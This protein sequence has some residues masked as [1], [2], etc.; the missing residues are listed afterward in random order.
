MVFPCYFHQEPTTML[1][2]FS[3]ILQRDP[4]DTITP[5]AFS[6][7]PE[8]L[9]LPLAKPVRRLLAM[10]LDSIVVVLISSAGNIALALCLALL[11]GQML[12]QNKQEVVS[13]AQLIARWRKPLFG[14]LVVIFC[15]W[16]AFLTAEK[17]L[18]RSTTPTNSE[19]STTTAQ[20]TM[21]NPEQMRIQQLETQIANMKSGKKEPDWFDTA[22]K[23]LD[24][25]GFGFGWAAVYF[26]LITAWWDGQTLGKRM[27]KLR[28]IQLNGKKLGVWDCFNR[29]GGY[30]AGFA[31][32]LMGF[33]QVFWDPNRQAIHDR[34]SFTVVIDAAKTSFTAG[35]QASGI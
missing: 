28:V 25:I 35:G 17:I 22:Q 5:E 27:L 11:C 21:P 24:R 19:S 10:G 20:T 8:L 13:T 29:Y 33:A 26:S 34:I 4:R 2:K 1:N 32:G 14:L 18:G 12:R 15:L 16:A 3:A 9:G 31:T 6:V 7:A 23:T 30:A